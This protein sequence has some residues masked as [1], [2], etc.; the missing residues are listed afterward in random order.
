MSAKRAERL[1]VMLTIDEVRLV[2]E[3]RFEHRMPSRSAAVRALMNLGLQAHAAVNEAALLEGSVSSRDVGV[4]ENGSLVG[5]VEDRRGV[6]VLAGDELAGH[7]LGR[8]VEWA[9]YRV[10]G[11][12]RTLAEA[13][14]LAA[15]ERFAAAV[16]DGRAGNGI[17][18]AVTDWLTS[19]R[20]PCAVVTDVAG[21]GAGA[22][23]SGTAVAGG[24]GVGERLRHA[25]SRLIS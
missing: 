13:D 20:V 19:Q 25:L 12:V 22:G 8:V 16:L 6:L 4:A 3:W 18:S 1:Q 14:R 5:S 11:P 2:E 10:V 17:V 24:A 7:G 23:N 21:G 9:G 15:T